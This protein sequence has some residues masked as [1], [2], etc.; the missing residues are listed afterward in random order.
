MGSREAARRAKAA[1]TKDTNTRREDALRRVI[2]VVFAAV[3]LLASSASAQSS[4]LMHSSSLWA[5]AAPAEQGELGDTTAA[6]PQTHWAT[7][8]II[9]GA[10]LGIGM[11]WFTAGMCDS[12]SGGGDCGAGAVG[13]FL[14]GAAVGAG[15]GAFIGA[16]FPKHPKDSLPSPAP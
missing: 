3:L 6:R 15:I 16:R 13:G 7:G 5:P 2:P 8:A 10:V 1:R 12:D 9:G 4:P 14:M 11:A